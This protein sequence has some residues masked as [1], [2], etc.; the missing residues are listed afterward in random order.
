MDGTHVGV[1]MIDGTHVDVGEGRVQI[2]QLLSGQVKLRGQC[3]LSCAEC[4]MQCC[5]HIA[6]LLQCG[7]TVLQ[8]ESKENTLSTHT[9]DLSVWQFASKVE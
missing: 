3:F 7:L 6:Q 8:E 9:L 1:T 5:K 2:T 4:I